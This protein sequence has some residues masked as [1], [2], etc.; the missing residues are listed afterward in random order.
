M[1]YN[2]QV[3][4]SHRGVSKIAHVLIQSDSEECLEGLLSLTPVQLQVTAGLPEALATSTPVPFRS[5]GQSL[6][7]VSFSFP[8]KVPSVL[9]GLVAGT[10]QK[11]ATK[12][13]QQQ[14]KHR[15]FLLRCKRL[16]KPKVL[17]L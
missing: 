2:F 15:T 4:L 12:L 13:K 6:A 11:E 14:K 9:Q 1:P 3:S 16:S 17:T 5:S 7:P 10:K 8:H